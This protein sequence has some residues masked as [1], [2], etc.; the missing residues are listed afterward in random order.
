M[1]TKLFVKD[2]FYH[3][4]KIIKP[5]LEKGIHVISSRYD[6]STL[7]YQH[8]QG[9]P[10]DYLLNLHKGL[11]IPDLTILIDIKQNVLE[12]RLSSANRKYL[13]VFERTKER[14]FRK[15][16]LEN[17]VKIA[18]KLQLSGRNI[19]IINGN[20]S[21]KRVFRDIKKFVDDLLT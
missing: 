17:Y 16:L 8:T 4:N 15:K 20:K 12:K 19:K 11:L 7:A 10:L 6:L 21:E 1:F 9:M 14:E 13:E 3:A 2:R 18:K 5:V